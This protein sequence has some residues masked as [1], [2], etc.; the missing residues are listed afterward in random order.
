MD[1]YKYTDGLAQIYLH[2]GISTLSDW[3]KYIQG[4]L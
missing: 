2:A 3:H 4:M 1:W